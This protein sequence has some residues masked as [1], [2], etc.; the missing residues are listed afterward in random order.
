MHGWHGESFPLRMPLQSNEM[1]FFE[2]GQLQNCTI[3]HVRMLST[4]VIKN[5]CK[6]SKQLKHNDNE[7][8]VT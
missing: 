7:F 8:Q 3:D 6:I 4:G 5:M 1:K 2:L